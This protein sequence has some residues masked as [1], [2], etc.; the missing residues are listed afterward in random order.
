MI[1]CID[2]Y[3]TFSSIVIPYYMSA[4]HATTCR[5]V[6]CDFCHKSLTVS[7]AEGHPES[8]P[9]LANIIRQTSKCRVCNEFMDVLLLKDHLIAH[10]LEGKRS[11]AEETMTETEEE[12][13]AKDEFTEFA[14]LVCKSRR[15]EEC[16]ICL[17]PIKKGN[18][19]K[20]LPCRHG[21]HQ[22]CICDWLSRTRQCPTCRLDI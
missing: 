9:I 3:E 14:S 6:A 2:W 19:M 12:P 16:T 21:F 18:R 5:S 10:E 7:E 8:C 4:R 17:D 15:K 22:R 13:E 11:K 20:V 1:T